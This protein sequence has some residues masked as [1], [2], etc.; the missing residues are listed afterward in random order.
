MNDGGNWVSAGPSA[1]EF[2]ADHWL[3][4]C[5]ASDTPLDTHFHEIFHVLFGIPILTIQ[6]V[7][8]RLAILHFHAFKLNIEPWPPN[9]RRSHPA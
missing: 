3:G 9:V 7:V 6:F 8:S 5:S 4:K 2:M 1:M